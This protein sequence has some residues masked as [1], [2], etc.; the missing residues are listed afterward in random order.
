MD[1]WPRAAASLSLSLS[2]SVCLSDGMNESETVQSGRSVR[3]LS[4]RGRDTRLV[5]IV[6]GG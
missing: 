3:E 2:V 4:G 6:V 5:I 1:G